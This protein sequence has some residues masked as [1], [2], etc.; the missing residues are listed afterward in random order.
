MYDELATAVGAV[1]IVLGL[2]LY[3]HVI[4]ITATVG[5]ILGLIFGGFLA[6]LAVTMLACWVWEEF[7]P[8]PDDRNLRNTGTQR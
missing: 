3:Y 7:R 4:V 8:S 6:L 1:L 2:L 5:L